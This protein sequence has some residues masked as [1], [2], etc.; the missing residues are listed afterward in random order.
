[1]TKRTG[2]RGSVLVLMM[3][4]GMTAGFMLWLVLDMGQATVEAQRIQTTADATALSALRMR[5]ASMETIADRWEEFGPWF[6]TVL[7]HELVQLPS[8]HWTGV[9]QKAMELKRALP[10]YQGR[11]TAVVSVVMDAN[12]VSRNRIRTLD[13]AAAK[14]DVISESLRVRDE[15]GRERIIDGGWVRRKWTVDAR[16]KNPAGRVQYAIEATVRHRQKQT[17]NFERKSD[18]RLVWDV[19]E[20]AAGKSGGTGGFPADWSQAVESGRL[21]PYR[22]A[23]Y[24]ATLKGPLE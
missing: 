20:K 3:F 7:G 10:G 9:E 15:N 23:R 1:M 4:V 21:N 2:S 18:A 11:V 14:L 16:A 13:N 8:V 17:W 22:L 6:G 5:A 24:R 19:L 12:G